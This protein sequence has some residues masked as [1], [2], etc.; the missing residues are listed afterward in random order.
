[1]PREAIF[2]NSKQRS[3]INGHAEPLEVTGGK[4][5]TALAQRLRSQPVG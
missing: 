1:M 4:I 3:T 2:S 5:L